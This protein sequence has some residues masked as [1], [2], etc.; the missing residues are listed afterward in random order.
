MKD[1]T[2]EV[3][4][5]GALF[6]KLKALGVDYV[7]ANSG[8]DFPPIIEGL[9]EARDRG[10]KLPTAIT[11][12][13]EHVAVGMA[14]GYAQL[15]GRAQAVMLHTNVGLANGA[16]GAI[17]AACDQI[18]MLLMSGRTPVM[19]GGRFG[20]RTV[21]IGWGQE[22]RDQTALV[23][24][25]CKWDY[26]LRFPEQLPEMLDRGWAIASS[27]P[28]GPVYM[29]LPREVLCDPSPTDAIEAPPRMKPVR[30]AP[31]PEALEEAA[32][33]LAGAERPLII[34]QRGAGSEAAFQALAGF[35]QDWAIPLSHY[36]ANQIAIPMSSPCHVEWM[37]EDL[38]RDADVILVLNALAPW[39]PDR[40]S[41][42]PGAKVIHLGPDPLFTRSTPMRNFCS[43]V[44]LAGETA[45]TI[46]AL[47]AAMEGRPRD[48]SVLAARRDR[49]AARADANRA[50]V[51]A[52]AE[53]G[54]GGPMTKE[55]VSLCLGRAIRAQDRPAS[56]FHELG[57]PLAP[58]ML[59]AHQSYFQ[60]PHSGGLGW[61]FPAALG[62]QLADPGR[63][64]FA[65]MGDGS[66]MFANP[67]VCHQVAEAQG[68]PVITLVLNNEE[69]GAVRHS[70][71]GLYKG[72]RAAQSND[73]PLT[74][75]RPSPDFTK[76]A[77]A[78][79]AHAETVTEG[80]D[81][82]A[83][84]ARAIRVATEERRQVL[85]NIAIAREGVH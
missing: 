44:A 71:E 15:T 21:P 65:T 19:E 85:L 59:D 41:P 2:R 79:R 3:S 36:W 20:A 73:V 80:R 61:G 77:E 58:L 10:M 12:P 83:A 62:A 35:V 56:V 33:L 23:R 66:Y 54:A 31:A 11:V 4:A 25:A 1:Q 50:A 16:T 18:P 76:T 53:R 14:H 72:G 84:L 9:I 45:P 32:A 38:L 69:W 51:I 63:L 52:A 37:P 70:V 64:I 81:L 13:H 22:M 60:E 40:A 82:P 39:W 57:A 34:A 75:L 26:E 27:T 74:S 43:D 78:S 67:T 6:G 55:W 8:T 7:F 28:T 68:L 48:A 42:A 17:N 46:L 49:I 5:G 29:S 30:T 47:I 24:E